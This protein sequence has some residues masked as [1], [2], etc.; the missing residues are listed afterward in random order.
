M[1]EQV[2]GAEVTGK[3][4]N[5]KITSMKEE[6]KKTSEMSLKSK[7]WIFGSVFGGRESYSVWGKRVGATARG[8]RS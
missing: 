4:K 7:L 5:V 2:F 6:K 3:M 1:L 8:F